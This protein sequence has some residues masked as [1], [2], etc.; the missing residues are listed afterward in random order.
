MTDVASVP[1]DAP[2]PEQAAVTRVK[3]RFDRLTGKASTLLSHAVMGGMLALVGAAYYE[4]STSRV[5]VVATPR[6]TPAFALAPAN[7][8]SAAAVPEVRSRPV[9]TLRISAGPKRETAPET[10]PIEATAPVP[11]PQPIVAQK[12]AMVPPIK[13]VVPVTPPLPSAVAVVPPLKVVEAPAPKS[14]E[15]PTDTP[16]S[17]KPEAAPE[18]Q[19]ALEAAEPAVSSGWPEAEVATALRLCT[20]MLAD[21]NVQFEHAN[22]VRQ[23]SCGTPAPIKLKAVGKPEVSLANPALMNCA[24]AVAV[25]NWVDKVLQPAAKETFA[26]PVVRL[27][28]TGS[29]TCRNR[30][31]AA[32]GPISEHAFGNAFDVSGFVL[33]DGRTINVLGGW[34]RVARDDAAAA[35]VAAKATPPAKPPLA[36]DSRSALKGPP[37]VPVAQPVQVA[38]M[39]AANAKPEATNDA[40][41]LRRIHGEAC[42]IF[43]TVLGPEANDAHRDHLHFD[44]KERKG[45][46]YCQ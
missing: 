26:S 4:R 36:P 30:N 7:S 41:F 24:V 40:K 18:N 38:A 9:T 46:S 1:D 31:G 10:P 22:P 2:A 20:A 19:P 6:T 16:T 27:V 35:K 43:G 17:T 37:I 39:P 14:A 44:L 42:A 25:G 12:S 45:K 21:R 5:A 32:D 28:G 23:G 11:S 15:P 29:Y 34:G 13:R 3:Q 33:A 8:I